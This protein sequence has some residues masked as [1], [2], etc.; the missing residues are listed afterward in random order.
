VNAI[1]PTITDTSL[2]KRILRNDDIREKMK[3]R[4][5]LKR[6][7][8]PSEVAGLACYLLSPAAASITGQVLKMD[9]GML[10]VKV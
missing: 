9:A 7:L 3:D 4:H 8:Q 1:A 6:I 5:P 2:A 10:S